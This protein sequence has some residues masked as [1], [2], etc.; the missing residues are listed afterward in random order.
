MATTLTLD[1]RIQVPDS[2]SLRDDAH[3]L[4][5]LRKTTEI[6][7]QA[8][9]DAKYDIPT[10]ERFKEAFRSPFQG[11]SDIVLAIGILVFLGVFW[12]YVR[13]TTRGLYVLVIMLVFSVFFLIHKKAFDP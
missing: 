13:N 3:P 12:L 2:V 9:A 10:P 8:T 5:V 11:P 7:N 4:N 6:Q 1:P